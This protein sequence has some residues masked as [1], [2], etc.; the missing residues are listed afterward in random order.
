MKYFLRFLLLICL[1]LSLISS[2]IARE[3]EETFKKTIPVNS[4]TRLTVE[5]RNGNIDISIWD[6]NEVEIIGH[7]KVRAGSEDDAQE[8]M[9]LLK[10]DVTVLASEIEVVT[11][12]PASG[13]RR[14]NGGF[15]EWLMGESHDISYSVSY[16]IKVPKEFD[17]DLNSSNGRIDVDGSNGR[18]RMETTNGKI[19]GKN[20]SG[21][22][23]CNTT[24]G[25]INVSFEKVTQKDEMSFTST[26]GSIK[27][28][29]PNDIKADVKA[30]TTNGS[31]DCDLPITD[32]FGGSR[33]QLD[34]E[35]NGGGDLDIYIKTTNGSIK[36]NES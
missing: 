31:I 17:L 33:K 28:Y 22:A 8:I 26:N 12:Y 3:I 24:N 29:L 15:F 2:I 5:N 25:S 36:I 32:R 20:I 4:S 27:L 16:E 35:I 11:D 14:G 7:K 9:E 21:S 30:R 1:S 34:A 23:R 19:N 13:N 18:L 10:I 6:R